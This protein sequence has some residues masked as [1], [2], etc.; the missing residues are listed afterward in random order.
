MSFLKAALIVLIALSGPAATAPKGKKP[1]KPPAVEKPVKRNIVRPTPQ[2]AHRPVVT[3]ARS[4]VHPVAHNYYAGQS[5]RS[6]TWYYHHHHRHWVYQVRY[7]V[8]G[9]GKR[10]FPTQ[11]SAHTYAVWI[12]NHHLHAFVNHPSPQTWVVHYSGSR[13]H[14]FGTYASLPVARRV[15]VALRGYGFS[16][17]VHWLRVYF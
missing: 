7:R 16:S 15:E 8:H 4:T 10:I 5:A 1:P 17:W 11:A 13:V 2:Q 9:W 14:P 12:R 3:H 6:R